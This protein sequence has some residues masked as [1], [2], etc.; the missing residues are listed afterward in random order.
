MSS[1][2]YRRPLKLIYFEACLN[3]Q[4]ATHRE[5]YLKSFHTILLLL[6]AAYGSNKSYI[7]ISIKEYSQ[8]NFITL[9]NKFRIEESKKNLLDHSKNPTIEA[10]A[11]MSGFNSTSSFYRIFKEFTGITPK[12]FKHYSQ[13]PIS[14]KSTTL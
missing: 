10:I 12:Q 9:I 14:S 7:S 5:K 3:Q 6:G 1:A 8:D 13:H 4:D 2:K 11:E